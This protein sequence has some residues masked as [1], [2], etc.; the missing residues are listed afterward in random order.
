M[1]MMN[2]DVPR[3]FF[4]FM[5]I[6]LLLTVSIAEWFGSKGNLKV[7]YPMNVVKYAGF[8]VLETAIAINNPDQA[9]ILLF[10]ISNSWGLAMNIKGIARLLEEEKA[11]KEVAKPQFLKD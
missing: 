2:F 3:W 6:F 4:T 8:I 11:K 7:L 10:N 5:T 1:E 9:A